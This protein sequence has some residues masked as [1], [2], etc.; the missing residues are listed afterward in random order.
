MFDLAPAHVRVPEL[1]VVEL[2]VVLV[3]EG[4]DPPGLCVV[5]EEDGPPGSGGRALAPMAMAMV[6]VSEMLL[7]AFTEIPVRSR[8]IQ[9]IVG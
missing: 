1:R 9:Q 6:T 4:E 7:Q 5:V 8:K 2:V 3:G